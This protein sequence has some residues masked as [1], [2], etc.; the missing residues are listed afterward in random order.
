[1]QASPTTGTDVP[2]LSWWAVLGVLL[3]ALAL[4][5]VCWANTP[6]IG[7]DSARFL[8]VAERMNDGDYAAALTDRYHPLT[9]FLIAQVDRVHGV[10]AAGDTPTQQRQRR[11]SSAFFL[12][13]TCGLLVVLLLM[14]ISH[15]V[16]P[17]LP[18]W[19]TGLLAACQPYLIRSAADI[20]SD[21]VFLA[22]FLAA[23]HEGLRFGRRPGWGAALLA[24]TLVG[25]AYLARPEGLLLAAVLPLFWA[26]ELRQQQR[27]WLP[28]TAGFLLVTLAVASPYAF[29]I[30]SLAGEWT[31]TLKKQL[32]TAGVPGALDIHEL[33]AA[34]LGID[35]TA[36]GT[37][38]HRWLTTATEGLGVPA[39]LCLLALA[40]QRLRLGYGGPLLGV[41]AVGMCLVLLRL[42]EIVGPTYISRRHVFTLMALSLPY[43]ALGLYWGGA[44]LARCLR[45]GAAQTS[46]SQT[47]PS[48]TSP[49][50]FWGLVVVAVAALCLV[51]KGIKEQRTDQGAEKLAGEF[52]LAQQG[53]GAV[54]VT[55]REKVAYYAQGDHVAIVAT[56]PA[57]DAYDRAWVVF[58]RQEIDDKCL[59]FT[60]WAARRSQ[61]QP[62]LRFIRSFRGT[63][64][65]Y[66]DLQLF[67]W[68]REG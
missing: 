23:L 62:G 5:V 6:L 15:W 31:F 1:M 18:P 34:F 10:F 67:L 54:V 37:I 14:R 43:A 58:Y 32:L 52:I 61:Q 63:S 45:S 65:R 24:G 33:R 9:A 3:L 44:W 55:T 8:R 39:A 59:E 21:T 17:Q 25:A 48:R 29:A 12:T 28:A 35:P 19:C 57:I 30:S 53:P 64:N 51:P 66:R 27:A 49:S 38:F 22:L 56:A 46:S 68:E 13:L 60:P 47:S 26:W 42:A 16:V 41:T 40:V 50:Q 36:V 20:M 2:R 4:R 11:E 7:T